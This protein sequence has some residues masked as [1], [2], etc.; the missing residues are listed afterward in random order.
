MNK[1]CS[2]K[3]LSL[4]LIAGA[5][6]LVVAGCS[7][8]ESSSSPAPSP[9]Q[10]QP[11]STNPTQVNLPQIAG[12]NEVKGADSNQLVQGQTVSLKPGSLTPA[13]DALDQLAS[14]PKSPLPK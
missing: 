8:H 6:L 10:S 3:L 5:A 11:T 7:H 12:K 9:A 2:L 4:S 13:K 1:V 14:E